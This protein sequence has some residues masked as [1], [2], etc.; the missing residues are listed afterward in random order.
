MFL[1]VTKQSILQRYTAL[2]HYYIIY[3][4]QYSNFPQQKSKWGKADKGKARVSI[5]S[6][7]EVERHA[8]VEQMTGQ[9]RHDSAGQIKGQI[10]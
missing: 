7:I 3:Y 6:G 5:K 1:F 10:N 9:R 4:I 8:T 2:T